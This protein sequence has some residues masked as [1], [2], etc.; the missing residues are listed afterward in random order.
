[1]GEKTE[2]TKWVVWLIAVLTVLL[3]LGGISMIFSKRLEREI[4]VTSHQYMEGMADRASILRASIAEIDSTLLRSTLDDVTRN[5]LESQ[6]SALN[7]QL[8]AI[9]R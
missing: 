9:R 4:L 6:R 7:I 3:F 5:N 2:A 1:M 8:N